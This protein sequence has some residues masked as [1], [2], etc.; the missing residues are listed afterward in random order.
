MAIKKKPETNKYSGIE[1]THF[2]LDDLK[3]MQV[4]ELT[5]K[6]AYS[7]MLESDK[8]QNVA[9]IIGMKVATF[10]FHKNEVLKQDK[11]PET[12]LM[13]GRLRKAGYSKIQ[14]ELWI[15]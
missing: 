8:A 12:D 3:N 13:R 9:K 7:Q 4:K 15:K 2:F 1:A 14:E 6:E 10:Y 11:F 5:V